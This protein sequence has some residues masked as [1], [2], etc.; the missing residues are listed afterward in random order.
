[1]SAIDCF[2]LEPTDRVEHSLRRYRNSSDRCDKHPLGSHNAELLLGAVVAGHNEVEPGRDVPATPYDDPRWPAACCCGYVFQPED[3]WQ[4]FT[5]RIYRRV[6]TG[7][8]M[9]LARAPAGA[10]WFADWLSD[11]DEYRGP[12][13]HTLVVRLPGGHDWVVDGRAN[14]C[15]MPGDNKHKCWVRHG[16]APKITVDKNGHTCSAGAGSILVPGYH[17]FLRNGQLVVA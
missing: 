15:T 3:N 5:R 6:D 17:G 13:G 16:A 10:M 1:M 12:D 7:A 2:L 4:D 11:C 8:E 9:T 14:N